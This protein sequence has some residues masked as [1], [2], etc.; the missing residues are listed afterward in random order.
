MAVILTRQ[1]I[2]FLSE[3]TCPQSRRTVEAFCQLQIV[4]VVFFFH[5]LMHCHEGSVLTWSCE[6]VEFEG[7]FNSALA[8]L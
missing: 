1:I 8:S 2:Q 6:V 7:K 4:H 5:M 3:L